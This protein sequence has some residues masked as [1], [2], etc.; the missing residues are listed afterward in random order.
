MVSPILK[1]RAPQHHP[2]VPEAESLQPRQL[3]VYPVT[4]H[5]VLIQSCLHR[6][7]WTEATSFTEI[8]DRYLAGLSPD[9][10]IPQIAA[11]RH[12]NTFFRQHNS[13]HLT[14][15]LSKLRGWHEDRFGSIRHSLKCLEKYADTP[16]L[17]AALFAVMTVYGTSN[18]F[19]AVESSDSLQIALQVMLR[20]K[21]NTDEGQRS[22]RLF[23]KNHLVECLAQ[24]SGQSESHNIVQYLQ[25]EFFTRSPLTESRHNQVVTT[26]TSQYRSATETE[27]EKT[28][29][30]LTE[31]GHLQPV[32]ASEPTAEPAFQVLP[33][34]ANLHP[35]VQQLDTAIAHMNH[36]RMHTPLRLMTRDQHAEQDSRTYEQAQALTEIQRYFAEQR[37]HYTEQQVAGKKVSSLTFPPLHWRRLLHLLTATAPGTFARNRQPTPTSEVEADWTDTMANVRYNHTQIPGWQEFQLEQQQLLAVLKKATLFEAQQQEITYHLGQLGHTV[38]DAVRHSQTHG[39]AAEYFKVFG[40]QQDAS[41]EKMLLLLACTPGRTD[42]EKIYNLLC[43]ADPQ[44]FNQNILAKLER[45]GDVITVTPD[46]S[47]PYDRRV[48]I[49]FEPKLVAANQL[50]IVLR[51]ASELMI[52]LGELFPH[53]GFSGLN[54]HIKKAEVLAPLENHFLDTTITPVV[55]WDTETGEQLFQSDST[56]LALQLNQHLL[57]SQGQQQP[58]S[59]LLGGLAVAAVHQELR[60]TWWKRKKLHGQDMNEGQVVLFPSLFA[61]ELTKVL[62]FYSK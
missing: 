29:Q 10:L 2:R 13:A 6:A 18:E 35:L 26:S 30:W 5:T 39:S 60:E 37:P 3:E 41:Q 27:R 59:R 46:T 43:T 17:R 42:A 31:L 21:I 48:L 49:I 62:T 47:S 28:W 16:E 50:K 40:L 55:Y 19:I 32:A 12:K 38:L 14:S 33:I 54:L 4:E 1:E 9:V 52:E 15:V 51:N 56:E 25:T 45:R 53:I 8:M 24:D 11:A 61:H 20:K 22:L 7:A 36:L 34:L 58:S 23:L 44:S 57:A